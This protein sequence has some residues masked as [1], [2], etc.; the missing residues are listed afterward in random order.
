MPEHLAAG[1]VRVLPQAA[2]VLPTQAA[3]HYHG[4]LRDAR[5]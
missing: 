2:C 4:M 3:T 1:G 5:R